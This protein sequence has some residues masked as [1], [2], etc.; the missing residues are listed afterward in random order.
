MATNPRASCGT[1][2]LA[3]LL[4]AWSAAVV[5][6]T[7]ADPVADRF[8]AELATG[9]FAPALE[10]VRQ[11]ADPDQ[12]AEA[13]LRVIQ[14]QI[15]GAGGGA[16]GGGANPGQNTAT[17]AAGLP[18]VANPNGGANAPDFEGLTQLITGTIAPT[19]WSDVGGQGAIR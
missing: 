9:E 13:A 7:A 2:F 1:I 11:L 12:Q 16:F 18:S 8:A 10:S 14:A 3:A 19:T 6:L 15:G 5:P 17:G 4:G